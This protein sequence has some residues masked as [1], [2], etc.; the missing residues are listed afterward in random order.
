MQFFIN[1]SLG[2]IT[3][4]ISVS[5]SYTLAMYGTKAYSVSGSVKELCLELTTCAVLHALRFAGLFK[6]GGHLSPDISTRVLNDLLIP[7]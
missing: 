3:N 2:L 7:N 1:S 4:P 5:H 6:I